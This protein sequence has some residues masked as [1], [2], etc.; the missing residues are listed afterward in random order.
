MTARR[1]T[2]TADP[3]ACAAGLAALTAL[4]REGR[5]EL[6]AACDA[7]AAIVAKGEAREATRGWREVPVHLP[8]DHADPM[9][10]GCN[11]VTFCGHEVG[12]DSRSDRRNDYYECVTV[13]GNLVELT[14]DVELV[15]CKRCLR[16]A[17][18]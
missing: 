8:T 10:A 18:R 3:T 13:V 14:D 9:P 7:L 11:V 15:T 17:K 12:I 6:A 2:I 16:G 4:R 1:I 5:G